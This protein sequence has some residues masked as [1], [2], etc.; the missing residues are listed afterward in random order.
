MDTFHQY[1]IQMAQQALKKCTI[2]KEII[3]GGM[4]SNIQP[5]RKN[6]I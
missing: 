6:V 5:Q 2:P 3:L 4:S 1:R